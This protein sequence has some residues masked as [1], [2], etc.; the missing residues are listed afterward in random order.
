MSEY[1]RSKI[2]SD[3]CKLLTKLNDFPLYG[4]P[5]SDVDEIRATLYHILDQLDRPETMEYVTNRFERGS[6]QFFMEVN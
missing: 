5:E 6:L 4:I 2:Q 1:I 3:V